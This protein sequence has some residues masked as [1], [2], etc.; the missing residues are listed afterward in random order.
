MAESQQ[1]N[2]ERLAYLMAQQNFLIE[3]MGAMAGLPRDWYP[4]IRIPQPVRATI[5]GGPTLNNIINIDRS[6]V[7]ML[8]TGQIRDVERININLSALNETGETEVVVALK[9]LTE[10]VVG[11]KE[12]S[13]EQRTELL[14]Q[15]NEL[16]NQA[17]MV[18]QARK[19][20]IIKPVMTGLVAGLGVVKGLAQVWSVCGDAICKY[21]GVENPLKNHP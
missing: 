21:L 20:G 14:D 13:E 19:V 4:Q 6:V 7:G 15:L 11:E 8:N 2:N 16:S 12:I 17:G 10:A 3:T 9:Q 5:Q 1:A 18:P